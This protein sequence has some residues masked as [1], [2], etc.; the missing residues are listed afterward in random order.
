MTRAAGHG[1]LKMLV[2]T[3]F[4]STFSRIQGSHVRLRLVV[5]KILLI[6]WFL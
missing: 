3:S 2:P 4:V 5:L 1:T 6:L